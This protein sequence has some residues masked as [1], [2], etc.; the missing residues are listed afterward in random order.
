M[1]KSDYIKGFDI[2]M[3]ARDNPSENYFPIYL[4]QEDLELRKQ[5]L[6]LRLSRMSKDAS[7]KQ[8]QTEQD[9]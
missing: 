1:A 2:L 9:S 3:E 5:L 8:G 6:T 7:N 4:S